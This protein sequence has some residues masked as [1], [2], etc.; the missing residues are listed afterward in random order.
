MNQI[1]PWTNN[2]KSNTF[3]RCP[4]LLLCFGLFLYSLEITFPLNFNS[5][6]NFHRFA[7]TSRS[8]MFEFVASCVRFLL[9]FYYCVCLSIS[10][11][12]SQTRHPRYLLLFV[13]TGDV[14]VWLEED[15]TKKGVCVTRVTRYKR[16]CY[17]STR[18]TTHY[19]Y[20]TICDTSQTHFCTPTNLKKI[21]KQK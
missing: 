9:C 1:N 20:T 4:S 3:S 13:S 8:N 21:R 2:L 12:S 10:S 11:A 6:S 18:S 16:T 14:H 17:S 15:Q 19:Y 5:S 7:E